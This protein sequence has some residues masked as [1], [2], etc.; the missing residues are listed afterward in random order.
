MPDRLPLRRS[1]DI[2]PIFFPLQGSVWWNAGAAREVMLPCLDPLRFPN[3]IRH[4]CLALLLVAGAISGRA[5]AQSELPVLPVLTLAQL[6]DSVAQGG[7]EDASFRLETRIG[8]ISSNRRLVA[9]QDASDT[10]L[11][12]CSSIPADV[13]AGDRLSVEARGCGL[14][15]DRHAIQ[16]DTGPLIEVDNHHATI[17]RSRPVFLEAGFQPIRVDWFNGLHLAELKLEYEGPGIPLC[18][19]PAEAFFH[20]EPGGKPQPGLRYEVFLKD[21]WIGLADFEGLAPVRGDVV[22]D[23]DIGIRPQVTQC[24]LRFQG[25]IKVPERGVYTFH[26][27]SD[28][29]SQLFVGRSRSTAR[30]IPG[31]SVVL[32]PQPWSAAT[33]A[34][35]GEWSWA[36]GTVTFCDRVDGRLELDASSQDSS[37]HVT[38]V[39]DDGLDARAL[40]G[41]HIKVTGI[42]RAEGIVVVDWSDLEISEVVD[43]SGLLTRAVQVRR[44][45]PDEARKP[46]RA[47]IRGVVTMSSETTVVLQDASGG[48]FINYMAP[49]GG[50]QPRPGEFWE[51]E[52]RTDPGDFSPMLYGE[53][54][55]FLGSIAMPQAARPTWEQIASGSMDA[56]WVEIEGVVAS[57]TSS[58]LVLI[59]RGGRVQINDNLSYPLTRAMVPEQLKALPGAV[60]RVR[61]V[62]TANWDSTGRVNAGICQ[63]GN[64]T[65]SIDEPAPADPFAAEP[66]RASDLLLFS[67]HSGIFKRVKV[68]GTVLHA[69]PPELFLSDGARGF[70]I[71]SRNAPALQAGD[72]VE[73]AGF[74]R[75]GGPSPVL[76]EASVRKTGSAALPVPV[77]V[78][79]APPPSLRPD[80]VPSPRYDATRVSIEATLLSD[81]LRQEERVL[82]MQAGSQRFVARLAAQNGGTKPIERGS[83][84]RVAGTYASAATGRPATGAEPFELLLNSAAD[85]VVLKRGPWWTLRHT[86]VLVAI[87]SGG[88]LLVLF[89]N[90]SLRRTVSQRTEQLASEIEERQIAEHH[91]ELEAE[92]TRV[93]H[94]LHDE[95]GAGLTEAGIL[96]SLV[97]NPAVAVDKK[98]GYLE[99]LAEVCRSLVT[100]LD[101]IVWAVNPRYDSAADLAGYFSIFAQRFLGLAGITCRLKIAESLEQ[102][103]LDSHRRHDLFLAF[104]EALNNIARHSQ[105]KAVHLAISV[106]DRSLQ[107]ILSDDGQGF[108]PTA[109]AMGS[110]GVMSMKER[111]AKLGG[112]CQ[113][114]SSHG[115]GTT[116]AFKLPLERR[117]P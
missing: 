92:R 14:R 115:T 6:R 50:L 65:L 71:L 37:F 107:V 64:A 33:P 7:R 95:L 112:S 58:Q 41:R 73:A 60:V 35:S 111:L 44:L 19:V 47:Q 105:A 49:S 27:S 23:L 110:D 18:K 81:T 9:V 102:Q 24:G 89:W 43:D 12:E 32:T 21:W 13:V 16:I 1:H 36:E 97:K 84:L 106:E 56:E 85:L 100:G 31:Q 93:A 63:M 91:R 104:K 28:D 8:A 55:R 51:I 75:L 113:I 48:V 5:P 103:P 17:T 39:D 69:H 62:F 66:M 98:E 109:T 45:R 3:A 94:D 80:A 26:L 74:P 101:E 54:S 108:D 2:T 52:G 72:R 114:D 15:R 90:F 78:V 29:G 59:T 99:Q 10:L 40:L 38:V 116:V 57:V 88:L 79:A 83:L 77:P 20:D 61:G 42:G 34:A 117:S 67:T 86:I 70:R 46:Y 76:M 30:Q 25:L 82:E 4:A 87:L 22:P 68:T 53:S 11:L 96:T